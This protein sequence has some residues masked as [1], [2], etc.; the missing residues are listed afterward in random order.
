MVDIVVMRDDLTWSDGKPVTAHGRRLHLPGD[1]ERQDPHPRRPPGPRSDAL[2]PRLRRPHPRLL[3]QRG[4]GH[5]RRQHELPHHP[6]ARLREHHPPRPHHRPQRRAP[7][8][9]QE[10]RRR[11]RLHLGEVGPRTG[12]RPS[13]AAR[14]TTCTTASR[15]ARSP[16]FKRVRFKVIEDR[17][18]QLLALRN[19]DVDTMLLIPDQWMARQTNDDE[20]YSQNTK[21][22]GVEWTSFHFCWNLETPYF[23]GRARPQGHVLGHGL[24]R[25]CS[26]P[27]TTAS[28]S[29]A[30]ARSTPTRGC[31]PT[32]RPNSTTRTS[33]GPEELLDEAGWTDSDGDG[34]RDKEIDGPPRPLRVHHDGR[35]LRRPHQDLHPHEGMPRPDR[36]RLPR[37]ADRVHRP[38]PGRCSTRKFQAAFAGWGTGARPRHLGQHLVTPGRTATTAATPTPASTSSSRWP[39]ASSTARNAPTCTARFHTLLW[40]DQPYTWLFTRNSF[41]AF[42][43]KLRGYNF[44]PRGPYHYGPRRRQHLHPA[45][46]PLTQ[47][48][49]IT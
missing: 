44:S 6:Q 7:T 49:H 48:R 13:N 25:A 22:R 26:T 5:Q 20:F 15:S 27:S 43:K 29:S 8:H 1:H 23:S 2:G 11:R 42:N 4:P 39:D 17:N 36:R 40:E 32:T 46:R 33:T 9:R 34:I 21:A 19:G 18:T 14:A 38:H 37:Q 30:R 47:K 35:Q 24:P 10:P 12:V 45:G 41:Y 31:S 3:P 16:Y 28:T